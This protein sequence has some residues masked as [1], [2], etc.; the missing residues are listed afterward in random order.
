MHNERDGL[1]GLH[2]ARE[3]CAKSEFA[4]WLQLLLLCIHFW[5]GG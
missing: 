2:P 1:Y 4:W 3:I 5:Y